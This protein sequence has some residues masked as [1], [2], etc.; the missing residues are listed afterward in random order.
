MICTTTAYE[1]SVRASFQ[2]LGILCLGYQQAVPTIVE[3]PSQYF[4]QDVAPQLLQA[5][6]GAIFSRVRL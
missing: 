4:L 6:H 5:G 1:E 2:R 3:E